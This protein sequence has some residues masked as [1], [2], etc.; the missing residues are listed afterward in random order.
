MSRPLIILGGGG[1]ARVLA[2][3]L[4]G[5]GRPVLGFAAPAP[6]ADL[7]PGIRYLGDDAVVLDHAPDNV[8][9]VNGVGSVSNTERRRTLY[10]Q[11]VARGYEFAAVAHP[12]AQLA[13]HQV[14]IGAGCQRLAT[15]VV[16]PGTRLG[17]NVLINTRAVVE[18]DCQVAD[19]CHVATGAIICGGCTLGPGVHVGAGAVIIQ[20][21]TIG[22]GAIIAAGAVVTKNVGPLTLVGGVPAVTLRAP[23]DEK[24]LEKH[25]PE[26]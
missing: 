25:H 22:S 4:L 24:G 6:Q 13:A 20:G 8:L 5:Q 1:H 2:D 3:I 18:H 10:Q 15:S 9:L 11:F 7:L 12:S 26:P 16:G 14:E 17:D 23:D 21:I 19:H